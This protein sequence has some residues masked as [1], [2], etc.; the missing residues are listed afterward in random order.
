MPR[1]KQCS[2]CDKKNV[3]TT[4]PQ[5]LTCTYCGVVFHAECSAT[6]SKVGLDALA[7]VKEVCTPCPGCEFALRQLPAKV[8]SLEK[9]LQDFVEKLSL[10]LP[11]FCLPLTLPL[12]QLFSRSVHR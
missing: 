5:G 6:F 3:D 2:V 8:A 10:P 11:M 7:I 12:P 4:A 1:G 9:R